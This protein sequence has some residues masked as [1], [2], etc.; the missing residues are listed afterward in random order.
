MTNSEDMRWWY[1]PIEI[2]MLRRWLVAAFLINVLLLTVDYLRAESDLLLLGILTCVLFAAL[3]ASLPN[4]ND[5]LRRNSCLVLS[6]MLLG[7]GVYRLLRIE[8]TVFNIWIHCW[9][10]VPSGLTLYWLSGRPVTVWTSRKLSDS[11]IEYGLMRNA[12]LS[13]IFH[14]TS[15]HLTLLHFVA[16]TVIPLIWIVD[17][18]FSE[19]NALGGQIGD[20]FTTKHFSKILNGD[21]F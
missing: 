21:S 7:I 16:I 3:R 10:I 5:H 17:I 15:T 2:V 13:K 14:A 19:G 20:S 6:A 1:V 11:A 9:S 8:V 12:N 4:V 18:A